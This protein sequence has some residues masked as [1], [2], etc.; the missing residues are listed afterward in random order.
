MKRNNNLEK[1]L[2]CSTECKIKFGIENMGER[3]DNDDDG[4]DDG[5]NDGSNNDLS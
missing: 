3:G 1:P 5:I 4:D 2:I